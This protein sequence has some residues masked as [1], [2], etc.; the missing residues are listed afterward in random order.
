MGLTDF[1]KKKSDEELF[2][3][4]VTEK[5][6]LKI[7]SYGRKLLEKGNASPHIINPLV[8]ALI[9]VGNKEEAIKILDDYAEEKLKNGYY[10]AA[11]AFLQ[12]ALKHDPHNINTVELLSAAYVKKSLYF[13]AFKVLIDL[14]KKLAKEGKDVSKIRSVIEHFIEKNSHPVF[15]EMYA[16]ALAESNNESEAYKNYIMAG[17]MYASLS[18]FEEAL[19]TYLKAREIKSSEI[20]DQKITE[21]VARLQD[22][23][24]RRKILK[25]LILDNKDNLDLLQTL[26]KEFIKNKLID[27]V[28]QV[29]LTLKDTKLKWTTAIL[30]DIETGEIESAFENIEQLSK[31]DRGT[32]EKLKGRLFAKYPEA[33]EFEQEPESAYGEIP[34]SDEILSSIFS[35]VEEESPVGTETSGEESAL[36]KVKA[37][38]RRVDNREIAKASTQLDGPIYTISMAEAMLGLGNYEKAV[39]MA[40]KALEFPEVRFRAISLISSALVSQ[41][42]YKEALN[43]LLDALKEYPFSQEE[44]K[45]IK[46][47]IGKIYEEIGDKAK[48]LFWY[49]EAEKES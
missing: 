44:R 7:V 32:A 4:A 11:I 6:Y 17:S 47:A 18:K 34:S 43:H 2:Q 25:G 28:D 16:D 45:N 15:Y 14:F 29:I 13:E 8:E 10:A 37:T 1:F 27:D 21:I 23:T 48:A 5:S 30:R 20:V 33:V 19:S 22:S 35:A 40:K 39:E 46:E 49:R 24:T 42:K 38:S 26:I 36:L 41:S 9:K 12:K 31:L 3:E